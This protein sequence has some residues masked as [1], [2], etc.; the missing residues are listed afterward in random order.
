MSR[1]LE[2]LDGQLSPAEARLF[3]QELASNPALR[4]EMADYEAIRANLRLA[5]VQAPVVGL[6]QTLSAL[7]AHELPWWQGL[8]WRPVLAIAACVAGLGIALTMRPRPANVDGQL[9]L[10][11]N[12][13]ISPSMAAA[14][15]APAALPE[16]NGKFALATLRVRDTNNTLLRAETVCGHTNGKMAQIVASADLTTVEIRVP[17]AGFD[18]AWE[19]ILALGNVE[20]RTVFERRSLVEPG[21][22]TATHAVIRVQLLPKP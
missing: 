1:C 6:G 16:E 18:K 15:A 22:T 20:A 11:T 13:T 4:Q 7:Q 2:Y 10:A 21:P 14:E 19:G 9:T 17:I 5:T 12:A 8:P 3:E